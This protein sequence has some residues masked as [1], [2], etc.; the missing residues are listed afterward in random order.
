MG[1]IERVGVESSA[2]FSLYGPSIV[3]KEQQLLW[4]RSLSP[5]EGQRGRAAR[6]AGVKR[7]CG[8]LEREVNEAADANGF[9]ALTLGLDRLSPAPNVRQK[10]LGKGSERGFGQG[11]GTFFRELK[12]RPTQQ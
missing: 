2:R 5:A 8:Q 7:I 12:Q 3:A 4:L 1:L 11:A 9:G 6:D 10:E